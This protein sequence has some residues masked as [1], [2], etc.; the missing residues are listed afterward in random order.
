MNIV[1]VIAELTQYSWFNLIN[2][3]SLLEIFLFLVRLERFEHEQFLYDLAN[4]VQEKNS[5]MHYSTRNI[6]FH[7]PLGIL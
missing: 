5:N 6:K 1:K 2:A 4:F 7:E 3:V